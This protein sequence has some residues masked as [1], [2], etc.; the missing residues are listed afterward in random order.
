MGPPVVIGVFPSPSDLPSFIEAPE[1]FTRQA[2]VAK[3][4]VETFHIAV[5]P[6][7]VGFDV[8]RPDVN[9]IEE[10]SQR[11]ADEF[12]AVVTSNLLWNAACDKQVSHQKRNIFAT[13]TAQSG[14][15]CCSLG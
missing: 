13:K 7:A 11:L 14:A 5:L 15:A 9:H 12:R 2:F 8:A 3:P 10:R 6:W 1:Q 4:A